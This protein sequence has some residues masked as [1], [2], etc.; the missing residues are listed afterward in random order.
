MIHEASSQV[1]K[2]N[3]LFPYILSHNI[4]VLKKFGKK[5]KNK[6][7]KNRGK[8]TLSFL[9]LSLSYN[10][11][12]RLLFPSFLQKKQKKRKKKHEGEES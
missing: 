1:A 11:D 4:F 5:Q 6:R 2:T 8:R 12:R 3:R 9:H 10:S 7:G